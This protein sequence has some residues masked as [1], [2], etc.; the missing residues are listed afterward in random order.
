MHRNYDRTLPRALA[1]PNINAMKLA[2]SHP[3]NT[4]ISQALLRAR[5]H[6]SP[7]TLL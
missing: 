6:D 4:N 2:K 1:L 5:P 3:Q 7:S